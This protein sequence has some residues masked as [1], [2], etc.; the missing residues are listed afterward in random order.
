MDYRQRLLA[1]E[2]QLNDT[3]DLIVDYIHKN[4]SEIMNLSIRRIAEDLYLAP[5]AVM[6]FSKKIGYSGFSELKYALGNEGKPEDSKDTLVRQL[7]GQLPQNIV[8]TLDT[9]DQDAIRNVSKS[10]KEA[11]CCILAGVGDSYQF[12]EMM[13]NNL[14]CFGKKVECDIHIHDMFYSVERGT[15]RDILL[16]ISARGENERLLELTRLAAEK[17]MKTISITHFDKNPLAAMTDIQLYFWGEFRIVNGYNVTDRCGLM[18]LLR[19]LSEDF[20]NT[21]Y[22][23]FRV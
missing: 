22:M 19:L 18:V 5:N 9:I 8:K 2:F 15:D 7:M 20:W 17:H 11:E 13:K 1:H 16:V 23:P 14:R 10:L 21:Y 6:R 4:R 12:C 3:D